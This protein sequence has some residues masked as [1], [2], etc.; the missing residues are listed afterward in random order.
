MRFLLVSSI[1]L[2]TVTA[3][4]QRADVGGSAASSK[5]TTVLAELVQSVAQETGQVTARRA[6]S[7]TSL[8]VDALPRSVQDA[9]QSRRLRFGTNNDVQVYILLNAVTDET[10]RQLTDAGAVIEIRDA[11]RRRVQAHVPVARLQSIAQLEIVDAIRLPAYARRRVGQVTTEGDAIL[12]ADAVRQQFGLDGTG[13]RVGVVSDGLKGVFAT[14][15]TTSCAGV[16]GGPIATGD[17][18]SAVGVRNASGVLTGS[19]GGI[20]GRSFQANGDLEGLPPSTPACAFAGAGAEGTALLEIVHDLAP[21][22]KLSFAN[23]DTDLAFSQ[24]VNFLA[25]SNDVVLDDI[26]FLGEPSDGTSAVS[27]NTAAALNNP[28]FPIRA[29][30][31]A[32][33][34]DADQHYYGTYEDSRIDGATI[35]GITTIGHLHLFQ[36]TE[37]TTDVLGLGAQPYNVISLPANGE[38]AIFLTWDDAFGASSNNY[39]LYLVQQSTGRVVAS[40]TD[41][42]SGRQD[43]A[44]AIDYVNRGAQDLFRIV[45]Q[46]VRDAAQ[47]K[48]LN[49]FS[50]QPECAA[51]GPQL[52]APPRHERHNYNTATRSVSA[53]G[54]AG[55]SPVAV[56]AVGAICS[57]SAAAAGSSS[58]ARTNPVSIPRT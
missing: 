18:P 34:N 40:S 35:P 37:D 55:G 16:A 50:I 19:T 32:V 51:A 42:Q 23:S 30:F 7:A 20:V 4:A 58:A 17:L 43:P 6:G 54:D 25:A 11:A 57:A 48:H 49:I 41:I 13:V 21:G 8:S 56:I 5:L 31:T 36:R 3:T 9:V 26:G 46:N 29:Y 52:L 10:V 45:V 22:A 53:Q 44:E 14:G 47:P 15:C 28:S 2:L 1:A 24:A 39:D 38:V 33:G 27:S 12:Y